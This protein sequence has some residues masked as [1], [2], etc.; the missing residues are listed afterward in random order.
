MAA[1]CHKPESKTV[2]LRV[3]ETWANLADLVQKVGGDGDKPDG[4]GD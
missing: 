4:M 2:W 3:A 1:Y